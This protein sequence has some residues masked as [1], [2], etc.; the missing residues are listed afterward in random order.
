MGN[1]KSVIL[2]GL[3]MAFVTLGSLGVLFVFIKPA[4]VKE[5]EVPGTGTIHFPDSGARP[6]SGPMQSSADASAS[7]PLPS[8]GASSLSMVQR[9]PNV[10]GSAGSAMA[11][12]SADASK[13]A[14]KGDAAGLMNNLKEQN[15]GEKKA[16]DEKARKAADFTRNVMQSLVDTVGEFQP[17]WYKEYL[18]NAE[19]KK[20]AD[21]YDATKDFR[22]FVGALAESAAF[23]QMLAA[24]AKNPGMKSLVKSIFS[25]SKLAK[26]LNRVFNDNIEDAGLAKMVKQY[27]RKCGLPQ[28]MLARASSGEEPKGAQDAG[29]QLAP[30]KK[31]PAQMKPKPKLQLQKDAFG[32]KGFGP[33]QKQPAD[34]EGGSGPPP[35]IDLDQINKLKKTYG[36]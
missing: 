13:A 10:R 14:A 26:D 27:G 36:R 11:N 22:L 34:G 28:D 25:D 33:R 19:L 21:D 6:A 15:S 35:E 32:G 9:D 18:K 24:K 3:V 30:P 17:G 16:E 8:S 12:A 23:N 5:A 31:K 1:N 2:L 4:G 29:L 7:S 20:I